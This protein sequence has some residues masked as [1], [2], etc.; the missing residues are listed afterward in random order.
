[1]KNKN[2]DWVVVITCQGN[3]FYYKYDNLFSVLIAYAYHYL[4]K[5]KYGTMNFAL[6]QAFYFNNGTTG[7]NYRNQ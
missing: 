2:F 3:P 6:R 7:L 1:M 4:K 5:R